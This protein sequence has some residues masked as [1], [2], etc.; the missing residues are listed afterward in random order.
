MSRLVLALAAVAA[1]CPW[2]L[3]QE[4]A[5][6]RPGQSVSQMAT[7]ATE[8]TQSAVAAAVSPEAASEEATQPASSQAGEEAPTP[9]TVNPNAY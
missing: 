2:A 8:G 7:E 4:T 6:A 3:A 9:E 1:L 5:P